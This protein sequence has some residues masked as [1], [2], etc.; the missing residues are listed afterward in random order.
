MEEFLISKGIGSEEIST[1]KKNILKKS[2]I[3]EEDIKKIREFDE[4]EHSVKDIDLGLQENFFSNH[5][6]G[7]KTKEIEEINNQGNRR[8][9]ID[10][11]TNEI[12][13]LNSKCAIF[14]AGL[15]QY[16]KQKS[17]T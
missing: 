9:T 1:I 7:N 6:S 12:Q 8:Q 10:Q 11:L 13:A 5:I 17:R 2:E 4:E 16:R 14:K 3:G 15:M